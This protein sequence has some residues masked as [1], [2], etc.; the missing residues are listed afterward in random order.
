V[1]EPAEATEERTTRVQKIGWQVEVGRP[2]HD[3]ML[4]LGTVSS[5]FG[6]L[7]CQEMVL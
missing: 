3:Y 5:G 2:L 4:I 7:P 6:F 1:L